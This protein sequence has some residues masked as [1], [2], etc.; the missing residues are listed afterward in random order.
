MGH[1]IS[2]AKLT[3]TGKLATL[4]LLTAAVCY[5]SP[6]QAALRIMPMG[7]SITFGQ[8]STTGN[9][10][11]G[12]LQTL[13]DG[14]TTSYDFVGTLQDGTGI[15][16]DHYGIPGIK[17]HDFGNPNLSLR[18]QLNINSVFPTLQLA[19]NEPD[20]ILLHIQ[21]NSFNS[22]GGGNPAG[23]ELNLLLRALTTTNPLSSH[24]IGADGNHEIVLAHILPKAGNTA[25]IVNGGVFDG[26]TEHRAKVMSTFDFNYGGGSNTNWANG[27]STI[28]S[29]RS[30]VRLVDMFQIDINSLNIQGLLDEFGASLGITTLSQM[31]DVLS[32][33]DDLLNG[34][35]SDWVDWV[36]N[37]DEVNNTFG[38]G[39]D[40]VNTDLY[41][42]GDT[43][44]PSDLGYAVMAQ[45]WFNN[46]QLVLGDIDGDKFVGLT[47]INFVLNHW[48]QTV[49]PGDELL[50]DLTGDGFVGLDD[51]GVILV[52][53]NSS[54][55]PPAD[56]IAA[57][58]P[59]P[60]AFSIMA[61]FS[62]ALLR[63]VR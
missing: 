49:T 34:N 35:A 2:S 50:G 3:R 33:E 37:Y 41:S 7:D 59:E 43:I 52:N 19:G 48:N 29:L 46:M 4:A 60:A 42:A 15:D 51:L 53:W 26:L 9:G 45:V 36:S 47:D 1:N 22:F 61:G 24:Y 23:T 12:S 38:L 11:R 32:P 5:A 63:R 21:T 16:L 10:Y 25:A 17:A 58:I 6:A 39:T 54:T 62:L 56:L 57:V 14:T 44:H 18:D 8:G 55:P 13:L 28:A 27:I 30:G 40:G 20:T 31:H